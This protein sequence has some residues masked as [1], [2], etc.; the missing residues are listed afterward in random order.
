MK[1]IHPLY[2][3]IRDELNLGLLTFIKIIET[4]WEISTYGN[5]NHMLK[6]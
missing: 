3:D 4:L 5:T 2:Q 1:N 6:L